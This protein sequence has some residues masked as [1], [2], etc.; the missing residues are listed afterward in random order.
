MSMEKLHCMQHHSCLSGRQAGSMLCYTASMHLT[1]DQP[2]LY[3]KGDIIL[4]PH[5]GRL[6]I[7]LKVHPA[8]TLCQLLC[9]LALLFQVLR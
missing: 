9:H 1:L 6:P 5:L 7:I 2:Q 4:T 8:R 3:D